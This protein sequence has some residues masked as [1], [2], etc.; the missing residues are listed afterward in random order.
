MVK[1]LRNLD[2]NLL[3]VFEAIFSTGNISQAARLLGVSQPTISNSLGRLRDSLDDQLFIRS[4]RGV[5]PTAKA[6]EMIVPIREALSAIEKGV[7]PDEAF[8]PIRSNRH[9]R[10]VLFDMLESV[11]L[12]AVIREVQAYRSVTIEALP[13]AATTTVEGMNDGTLD[14]ALSTYIHNLDE[15]SCEKIGSANVVMVARRDHPEISGALTVD[16]FQTLGHVA[17]IPELRAMSRVDEALQHHKIT[18]HIVYTVSKF[19]SFPHIIANS[20]LI[21]LLPGDFAAEVA[22]YYPLK[23]HKVPFDLPQQQIYMT[24]K[25]RLTNDPGHRWLRS[26]IFRAYAERSVEFSEPS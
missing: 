25:N 11:L 3:I 9:F 13:I 10:I 24:W 7:K 8:D 6:L 4:G 22:K 23:L 2:L 12:P 26:L 5:A 16:H 18:R 1:S 17:L 20:D 14:M 15:F 19:W 21:A